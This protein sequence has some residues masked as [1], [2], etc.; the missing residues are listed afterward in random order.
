MRTAKRAF[1]LAS[2]FVL[3]GEAAAIR[4][5]GFV[6]DG[7]T[8]LPMRGSVV[9]LERHDEAPIRFVT[10]ID[11]HYRFEVP[12][13]HDAVIRFAEADRVSR[14]VVFDAI[15]VPKEWNDALH[16]ELDMRLYPQMDGLDSA[17]WNS[18]AGIC[19][20]SQAE[21]NMVWDLDRSAPLIERWNAVADAHL[22]KHPEQ[23]PSR[24]QMWAAS[25]FDLI[26]KWAL[27]AV[28]A[29]LGLV[30]LVINRALTRLGVVPRL[31]LLFAVLAGSLFLVVELGTAVGPLRFLALFGLLTAVLFGVLLAADLLVGR[32][33]LRFPG[34]E[35]SVLENDEEAKD[36]LTDL[37]SRSRVSRWWPL[38]GFITAMFALISE[39]V[40]GLENTLEVWSLTGKGMVGGLVAASVVAWYRSPKVVRSYPRLLIWSGGIWW[41]TLPM[42]GVAAASFLNRSFMEEM[43]WC[44]V[45]PVEEITHSRRGGINVRVSWS[46]ESERLEIPRNIKE[47][48]T[49]LD[50][51]RCC[52]RNGLLGHRFVVR[53]DP[54]IAPQEPR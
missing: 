22:V 43:E 47:Q 31:Y 25:S 51:L 38:I 53:I 2:I 33:A 32:A 42:L 16:A 24:I 48:L 27:F 45:W 4:V 40:Q 23:A 52:S 7:F 20:W 6:R 13:G 41:C 44:Q 29:M 15:K 5:E 39:G 9:V 46:G 49:T 18:P 36:V 14:Y 17:L 3:G 37:P 10:R 35:T 21:E 11:G 26:S 30:Y 34:T 28:V 12:A 54:I 8:R 19:T 1:L 50:S